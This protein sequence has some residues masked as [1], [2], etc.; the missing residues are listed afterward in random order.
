MNTP[1]DERH[2][3]P[4][5]TALKATAFSVLPQFYTSPILANCGGQPLTLEVADVKV[6]GNFTEGGVARVFE[7]FVNVKVPVK[8]VVVSGKPTLQVD[9]NVAEEFMV[10]LVSG[11]SMPTSARDALDELLHRVVVN[12]LLLGYGTQV[13]NALPEFKL[14]AVK[15][16]KERGVTIR[17]AA[18]DLGLH[19][20]VLRK[21]VKNVEVHREQ[22]FPGQGRLRPDDA[23]VARLRRELAKTKAERDILKKASA[24]FAKDS[25]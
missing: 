7:A 11:A 3:T 21:W 19:E 14:E 13:F 6:S 2:L 17:Q 23:E 22:A 5:Q 1:F 15:L 8:E 12:E 25:R 20:N 4:G 16:V 9:T 18:V 24:Y 10:E